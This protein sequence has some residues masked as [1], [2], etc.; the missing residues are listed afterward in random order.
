MGITSIHFTKVFWP[1]NFFALCLSS[2]SF[3]RS[4]TV[5][6]ATINK[7]ISSRKMRKEMRGSTLS[8]NLIGYFRVD[9]EMGSKEF[10]FVFLSYFW[11]TR[12][13]FNFRFGLLPTYHNLRA[14]LPSFSLLLWDAD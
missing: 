13:F 1:V 8:L 2:T 3:K 10:Q 6:G 12:K 9:K 11:R 7:C 14:G 4:T 5:S